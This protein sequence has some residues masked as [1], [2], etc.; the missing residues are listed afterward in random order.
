MKPIWIEN[1]N[2]VQVQG[3]V[4]MVVRRMEGVAG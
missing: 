4:V 1:P 3:K 2:V